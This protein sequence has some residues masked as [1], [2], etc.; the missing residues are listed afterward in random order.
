MLFLLPDYLCNSAA[1]I[2]MLIDSSGSIKDD[3]DH[4]WDILLAFARRVIKLNYLLT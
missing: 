3:G 2:C 1:D 4:N